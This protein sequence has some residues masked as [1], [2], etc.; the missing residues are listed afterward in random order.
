MYGEAKEE[1]MTQCFCNPFISPQETLRL[2]KKSEYK[3]FSRYL[4]IVLPVV[5]TKSNQEFLTI[6]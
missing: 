1:D 4:I 6:K 2:L 3:G 5:A